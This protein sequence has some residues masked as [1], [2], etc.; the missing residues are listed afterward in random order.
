M[1]ALNW[2]ATLKLPFNCFP[3]M[4]LMFSFWLNRKHLNVFEI[5]K[6]IKLKH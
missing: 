6:K 2:T 4:L 1:K 5:Y 3:A